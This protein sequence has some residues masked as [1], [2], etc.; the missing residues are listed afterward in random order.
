M[1]DLNLPP[2]YWQPSFIQEDQWVA[3]NSKED[4]IKWWNLSTF[5]QEDIVKD[6]Q[7]FLNLN[8]AL[9]DDNDESNV[10]ITE[11]PS[12]YFGKCYLVRTL[13]AAIAPTNV[14]KLKLNVPKESN[15]IKMYLAMQK[16]TGDLGIAGRYWLGQFLEY[17]F[18]GFDSAFN[19]SNVFL[20]K[21]ESTLPWDLE[22]K[23]PNWSEVRG[24][25]T[26]TMM[27]MHFN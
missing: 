15:G 8:S 12:Q 1:Q 13:Q 23:F 10:V 21:V 24:E 17:Q 9:I 22:K 14:M 5:S 27:K 19:I 11:I 3:P 2:D 6:A 26:A 20:F 25:E 4:L 7:F 18:Q 16:G